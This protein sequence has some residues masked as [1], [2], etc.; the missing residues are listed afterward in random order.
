MA[1][2]SDR[3]IV[4]EAVKQDGRA[5]EYAS[6]ELRGD[7][8]IVMAA[9]KQ[10]GWALEWASAE[11][12]GDRE[13]VMAAVKQNVGALK[14]ASVELKSDREIVMAA[15]KQN[16]AAL[17]LAE[18]KSREIVMAAVKQYG[19]ALRSAP[20]ELQGDREI[21]LQAV[22]QDPQALQHA[23]DEL[24]NG[25]FEDHV[26]DM[27]N[28]RFN[29]SPE[30]FISTILFGA[31]ASPAAHIDVAA[32]SLASSRPRLGYDECCFL[33]LLQ[34]STVLPGPLST[35]IKQLIWEYA[36]VRSGSKWQVI[37][38]AKRNTPSALNL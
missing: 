16:G 18:L 14:Y 25:G 5:L 21:V 19:C 1:E 7:Q 2:R 23:S 32:S 28:N 13:V 38:S 6:A 11:L 34:P 27:M 10:N 37:V 36:G 30:T 24:R 33:S 26:N 31:K 12:Q 17:F 3:E 9:V 4:M 29:V 20:V 22:A 8:E 35:Q 15:V